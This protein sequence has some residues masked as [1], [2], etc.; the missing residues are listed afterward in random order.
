MKRKTN[1]FVKSVSQYWETVTV[2]FQIKNTRR[3]T[4]VKGRFIVLLIVLMTISMTA[5]GQSPVKPIKIGLTTVLTGDRSLE[6]EYATNGAKIIQQEIND[7]GGVLG[8]PIQIVIEDALG[9]DVGAVNAYRKLADDPEIVAIIGSDSSN[10]NIAISSA[11]MEFEIPTTAQGSN[12]KL[13]DICDYENRWLFQL[14]ACDDTLCAALMRYAVEQGG[15][16]RF[17]LIHDTETNS[18]A[19]AR[20]FT[21]GLAKY[22]LEPLVVIPFT[23]G[24]KDFTSHITRIQQV[25]PEAIISGCFQTEAAI[26][27][28]QI[29]ALGMTDI[30]I[31]GSNAFADP[32]AIRLAGKAMNGVYS[33]AAWVPTTPNPKGAALAKKY[34]E[35][36]KED[37]GKAAAQVY[38]HVSI[39]VEAILRA[40]TTDRAAV[41]DAM[42]TID[43]YHGAI[44]R[45]DLR[46]NGDCGRGGLLAKVVNDEAIIVE[47]IISEKVIK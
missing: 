29:R 27:V 17:A 11:A 21:E 13:R 4:T 44:T 26:L 7:S 3:I 32:V 40:G 14:R 28:Q 33:A 43:D 9:T 25:K 34:K 36:Y 31:F 8:R 19:Q 45:Y 47:E 10:E 23:T 41:R 12:P 35:L 5:Y 2:P 38:D 42:N 22:G 30:P 46:T 15:Y 6:G 39:I 18:A 1:S 20:L 16:K 37:C 24:T